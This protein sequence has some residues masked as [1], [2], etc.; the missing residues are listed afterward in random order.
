MFVAQKPGSVISQVMEQ[1]CHQQSLQSHQNL[2]ITGTARLI[3]DFPFVFLKP[4]VSRELKQ[5][6]VRVRRPYG[7]WGEIL[8]VNAKR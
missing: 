6:Y 4:V 7:P 2:M 1:D 3:K 5:A 8:L